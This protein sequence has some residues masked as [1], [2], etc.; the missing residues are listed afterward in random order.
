MHSCLRC[1]LS[2]VAACGAVACGLHYYTAVDQEGVDNLKSSIAFLRGK[3]AIVKL[4]YGG[5]EH[6]NIGLLSLVCTISCKLEILQSII[7]SYFITNTK[8]NC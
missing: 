1:D 8:T 7:I 4:A 5:E 3:G 6:G 2:Q